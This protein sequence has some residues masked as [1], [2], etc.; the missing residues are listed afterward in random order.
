M[1]TFKNLLIIF[2]IFLIPYIFFYLSI[3]FVNLDF[4]FANWLASTRMALV[5]F[6]SV[7]SAFGLY[8]YFILISEKK[9]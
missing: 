5:S 2:L 9:K 7:F 6:G 4:N 8:S 1:K 3:G